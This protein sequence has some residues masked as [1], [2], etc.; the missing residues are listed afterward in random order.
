[1]GIMRKMRIFAL[2][3]IFVLLA[4]MLLPGCGKARKP[5]VIES[6]SDIRITDGERAAIDKLR[7]KN[8]D[9]LRPF[10]PL[11]RSSYRPSICSAY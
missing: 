2:A 9:G 1:M 6:L 7:G 3:L 10:L 8:K 5:G 11:I 4:G